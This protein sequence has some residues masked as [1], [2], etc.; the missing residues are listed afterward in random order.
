MKTIINIINDKGDINIYAIYE[1]EY[2]AV[3][4]LVT[5][6]MNLKKCSQYMDNHMR[7]KFN[8]E[9][10]FSGSHAFFDFNNNTYITK[11]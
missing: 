4:N 1:N 11:I 6:L 8:K 10:I 9:I 5:S 2:D 7:A 3:Y